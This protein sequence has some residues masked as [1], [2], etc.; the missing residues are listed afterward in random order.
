MTTHSKNIYRLIKA[1]AKD[2]VVFF[3]FI[4]WDEHFDGVRVNG[5]GYEL[6]Q[7]VEVLEDELSSPLHCSQLEEEDEQVIQRILEQILIEMK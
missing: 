3:P 6:F 1:I 7:L 4:V 2:K 5:T